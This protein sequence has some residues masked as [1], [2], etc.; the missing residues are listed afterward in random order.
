MNTARLLRSGATAGFTYGESSVG[1]APSLL[2]AQSR[3]A[4][5]A[6]GG[7]T[8]GGDL[9]LTLAVADGARG[10]TADPAFQAHLQPIVAWAQAVWE[11]WMPRADMLSMAAWASRRLASTDRP[12]RMVCGPASAVVAT[13]A[14]LGWRFRNVLTMVTQMGVELLLSQGP[15]ALV[16]S[17]VK[18]AVWQWRWSRLEVRMPWLLSL[19]QW[20]RLSTICGFHATRF[21]DLQ[22]MQNLENLKTCFVEL[23][24][25]RV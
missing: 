5:K 17:L 18:E 23:F 10:G 3:A 4:A 14:R 1:V 9:D 19:P 8:A 20:G 21:L 16:A 2:Q 25:L 6:L 11:N 12:W 13:M 15:P 7:R 22:K 24:F